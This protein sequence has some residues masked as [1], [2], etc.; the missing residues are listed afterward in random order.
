[1]YKPKKGA[2]MT[3]PKICVVGSSNVDLVT[4]APRLPKI[5]ETVIGTRF[6][7]GFGGKGAN[8]A[9]MAA[10]LGA[11]VT[12]ITKLGDDSFGRDTLENYKSL[13]FDS[14]QVL[15]TSEAATGVAPIW[16]EESSSN[17]AIIVAAGANDLLSP[18]DIA[19]ASAAIASAQV[20]VCQWEVPLETTLAA[21]KIAR[22][23][24]V[25][26]IFNP[27]PVREMLP[28][29]AYALSDIFSPNESE[30]EVLTGLS[31]QSLEEAEIAG[32][33]LLARGAGKVI[34]TLGERGSLLVE[35]TGT[36]HVPTT[37]VKAVDTTGAGDSFIGSL[38]YFL[39]AGVPLVTA[40]ERANYIASISVQ[41]TGTQS[42]FPD[43]A[44]LPPDLFK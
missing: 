43:R 7:T 20:L 4:Y 34:L 5:G 31:V 42:S 29:E 32:Q 26:T 2:I 11:E 33:S 22:Q 12:M 9:V 16:V 23:N 30:T 44:A 15:F 1:M 38:S 17:N 8:Q 13:G 6:Q 27:A 18:Q 24:G 21:L 14:S 28:D 40:M 35:S 25:M 41:A 19:D 10:K 36:T 3:R 37:V 39:G